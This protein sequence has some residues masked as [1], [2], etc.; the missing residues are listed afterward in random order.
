MKDSNE[1]FSIRKIEY[2]PADNHFSFMQTM[3]MVA[4]YVAGVNKESTDLK[5][6]ELSRQGKHQN[7]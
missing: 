1:A 4:S 5:M 7:R 6:F 2:E 3:V